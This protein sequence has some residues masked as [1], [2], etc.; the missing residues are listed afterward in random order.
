MTALLLLATLF[1]IQ[2][3]MSLAFL[4]TWAHCWLMF[5][6]CHQH[7]QVP[8]CLG[9]VQPHRPQPIMLQGV[10]VAKI[11]DLALV[12]IKHHL[13]GFHLSIQSFQVSLQSPPSFQQINTRSQLTVICKFT[14]IRVINKNIEQNWPQHRPLRDTTGYWLPAGCST[15]H[16]HS[17]GLA[18]QPVPNPVKSA[19]VQA[20]SCQLIQ[21]CAVGDCVKSLV[22][23]QIDNI[24]S[25]FCINRVGHLVIKGDQVGQT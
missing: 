2:A 16:H 10:I 1:L 24:H 13:N 12:L 7:H 14:L 11:Q 21:E 22:E 15:T 8:F 6:C 9:T 19:P 17:L 25:P 20:T 23:I 4:A 5:S 3:R 18:I